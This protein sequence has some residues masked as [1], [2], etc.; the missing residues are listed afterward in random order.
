MTATLDQIKQRSQK[1]SSNHKGHRAHHRAHLCMFMKFGF[2]PSLRG[3]LETQAVCFLRNIAFDS[4]PLGTDLSSSPQHWS[5]EYLSYWPAYCFELFAQVGRA[6]IKKL[7]LACKL[8]R[9]TWLYSRHSGRPWLCKKKVVFRAISQ[10][11]KRRNPSSLTHTKKKVNTILQW[12]KKGGK[13]GGGGG[14]ATNRKQNKTIP[15]S[16][17]LSSILPPENKTINALTVSSVE[18]NLQFRL[19]SSLS[20]LTLTLTG[21]WTAYKWS[22]GIP[23]LIQSLRLSSGLA[24]PH[25]FCPQV[26]SSGVSWRASLSVSL[27]VPGQGLTYLYRL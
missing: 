22:P 11:S 3:V 17:I 19:M 8:S 15:I 13:G 6:K 18:S 25:C 4:A 20:S 24:D 14:V 2:P 1:L 12:R 26:A 21:T 16:A 9:R 10:I 5:Q 27:W 7:A 23:I